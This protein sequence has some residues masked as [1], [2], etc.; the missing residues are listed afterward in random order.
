ML[1][2][3]ARL[4]FT[5]LDITGLDVIAGPPAPPPRHAERAPEPTY[6]SFAEVMRGFAILA[7]GLLALALVGSLIAVATAS[8]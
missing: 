3:F 2:D 1:R 6:P 8:P 7:A 5:R 4:I